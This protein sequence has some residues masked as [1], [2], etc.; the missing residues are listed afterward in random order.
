MRYKILVADDDPAILRAVE[1]WLKPEGYSVLRCQL[2]GEAVAKTL[3]SKPDLVLMDVLLGDA[4]GVQLCRRLRQDPATGHIPVILM[5][6]ARTDDE[7]LVSGLRGGAD[8]YLFK[9]LRRPVLLAKIDAV[10][11]RFHAPEELHEVLRRYGL[12]L[13]VSERTAKAGKKAVRLTRKEFDLLTVLLRRAG[14]VVPPKYLLET[15]WGYELETYN[16]THT[17]QVHISRLKKKLGKTFSS[18]LENVIGAGYRLS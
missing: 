18:R 4:D 13:D 12:E 1:S 10:L 11:R 7:D 3:S 17:V 14:K 2:G 15:V 5:S 9:P 8:D 6:G 16:D